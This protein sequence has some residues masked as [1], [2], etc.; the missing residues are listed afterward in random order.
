MKLGSRW[1]NGKEM[2]R[3]YTTGSCAAAAA[4]AAV[5][6]LFSGREMTQV[7]IDTPG[8]VRLELNVVDIRL[9]EKMAACSVRKDAGDDPD[10]THGLVVRAVARETAKGISI[11]GGEGVGTVTKP[12]LLVPVGEPAINPVP[13]RMILNEIEKALPHNK[14]VEVTISIPGG[15]EIAKK[16]FNPRLGIEGGL[17]ILGTTGIVEPMSEEAWQESLRLELKTLAARGKHKVILVPGNYGEDFVSSR[18]ELAGQPLVKF[19]NFAGCVLR[20]AVSLEFTEILLVGDLGKLIKVSAGIFQTHSSVADARM[21]IMAAYAALLG[22]SREAVQTLMEMN[23]TSAALD[24]LER[25]GIRGV[26]GLAARRVSERASRYIDYKAQIGAVLFSRSKGLLA[27]D[28][29]AQQLIKG[30]CDE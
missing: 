7:E 22:A 29:N 25:E 14:G 2:R 11:R 30:W 8:G 12:G 4:R 15:E 19:S 17:S 20:A 6:M 26:P 9:D 18:L 10:I 21:E 24:F 1:V 16:T 27:M 5:L 3:G 13:R 28:E 23:T